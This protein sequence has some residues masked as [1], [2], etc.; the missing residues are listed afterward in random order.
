MFD[1]YIKIAPSDNSDKITTCVFVSRVK[2]PHKQMNANFAGNKRSKFFPFGQDHF[3]EG[4]NG[5][6]RA[7]S[8]ESVKFPLN[9][10]NY[11]RDRTKI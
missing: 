6:D 8:L 1:P 9:S 11:V 7:V 4:A 10:K 3:S 5:F 2:T